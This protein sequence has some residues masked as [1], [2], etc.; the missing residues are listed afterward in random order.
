MMKQALGQSAIPRPIV[1]HAIQHSADSNK[2]AE[3]VYTPIK[4]SL[5]KRGLLLARRKGITL[6]FMPILRLSSGVFFAFS[7]GAYLCVT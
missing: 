5:H 4:N 3:L 6:H 2:F 7:K 1:L